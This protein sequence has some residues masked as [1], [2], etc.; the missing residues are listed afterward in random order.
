MDREAS[1]KKSDDFKDFTKS[2]QTNTSK[3]TVYRPVI[4]DDCEEQLT[5][6]NEKIEMANERHRVW[7][8]D[9]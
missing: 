1:L 7:L 5:R 3:T 4:Q 9:K 8:R 6:I 2:C